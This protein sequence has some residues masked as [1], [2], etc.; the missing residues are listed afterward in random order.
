MSGSAAQ[1]AVS[2]MTIQQ[3]LQYINNYPT[4][5]STW[6]QHRIRP[7]IEIEEQYPHRIRYVKHYKNGNTATCIRK[8]SRGSADYL[9]C[10]IVERTAIP[11]RHHVIVGEHFIDNPTNAPTIDHINRCRWDNH[12]SN[13]RWATPM[14]QAA[15]ATPF[16]DFKGGPVDWLDTLPAQYVELTDMNGRNLLPH[17]FFQIGDAYVQR[18]TDTMRQE[19]RYRRMRVLSHRARADGSIPHYRY[20]R[21]EHDIQI[22]VPCD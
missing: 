2:A 6:I 17:T 16:H 8:L 9:V 13:L 10:A 1:S 14:E 22:Q 12:V 21:D 7:N 5:N 18:Y 19:V 3:A 20:F 4:T 11:V 15:N